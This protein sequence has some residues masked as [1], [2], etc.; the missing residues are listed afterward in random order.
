MRRRLRLFLLLGILVALVAGIGFDVWTRRQLEPELAR[1]ESRYGSLHGRNARRASRRRRVQQRTFRQSRGGLDRSSRAP[2]PYGMADGVR[3]GFRETARVRRSCLETSRPSWT[4]T[5][6]AM[7]LADEAID[8][9]Q[10]SWD[11]DYAG[12]GNVPR[13]LDIRT[14]SDAIALAALLDRKAGRADEASRKTAPVWRSPPRSGM[15]RR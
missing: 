4:P 11:A 3:Q 7:R 10:A 15:S 9:H 1:L 2:A 5:R 12:G 13:L 6:E 8:R 14:L